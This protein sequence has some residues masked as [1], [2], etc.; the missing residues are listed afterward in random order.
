MILPNDVTTNRPVSKY[1]NAPSN[2][3]QSGRP[4]SKYR[5]TSK[6]QQQ[7]SPRSVKFTNN[8][9][10][11]VINE[12]DQS[13]ITNS[14]GQNQYLDA[15]NQ[16]AEFDMSHNEFSNIMVNNSMNQGEPDKITIVYE[17]FTE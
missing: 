7:G 16:D 15:Y 1:S 11:T 10:I 6:Y 4:I 17:D 13:A 9:N 8:Q 2:R 14:L 3:I 5:P 12:H